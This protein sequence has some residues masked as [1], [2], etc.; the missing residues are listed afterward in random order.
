M[1]HVILIAAML[2]VQFSIHAGQRDVT[3]FLGI[4]VDGTKPE[5][6]QKLKAK[7]FKSSSFDPE[8]LTGEFNGHDVH[9]HVV[10]NNNK[11][12]RIMVADANRVGERSIQIRFNRLIE[13]FSNN[14]KY[15][16]LDEPIIPDDEDISYEMSVHD[17]RYQATFYQR[18]E[19]L[20]STAIINDVR[21]L[22]LQKYSEQ[23]LDNLPTNA[24]SE[25]MA[26]YTIDLIKKKSVWFMISEFGSKYGIVMYYDNEYNHSNG[27]DL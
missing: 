7:G 8:I 5:M 13:Q 26:Q 12:W 18:P 1:K 4:P 27:E 20:D 15:I 10:T 16:S 22:L 24:I 17:K 2:L 25:I 6:I 23:E 3:K 14:A 11:V 21:N 9:I 19:I